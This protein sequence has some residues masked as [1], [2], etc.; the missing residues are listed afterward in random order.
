[1]RNKCS[2]QA[3]YWGNEDIQVMHE[4]N[5]HI[6][7]QLQTCLLE[8][9]RIADLLQNEINQTLASV[10]LWVQDAKKRNGLAE[11]YSF[12]Q[13]ELNLKAAIDQIRAVHYSLLQQI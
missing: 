5:Q 11:D 9:E 6:A 13:A 10:L 7:E 1:M 12:S 2:F 4:E 3:W 8:R